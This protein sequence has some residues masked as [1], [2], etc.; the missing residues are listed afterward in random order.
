MSNVIFSYRASDRLRNAEAIATGTRGAENRELVVALADLSKPQRQVLIEAVTLTGHV[1]EVARSDQY[2]VASWKAEDLAVN[3]RSIAVRDERALSGGL[4]ARPQAVYHDEPLTSETAVN[5]TAERVNAL[6]GALSFHNHVV[7]RRTADYEECVQ[8]LE[9]DEEL[10]YKRASE[11]GIANWAPDNLR[12]ISAMV[13]SA[14]EA[15][16]RAL[17]EADRARR[18]ADKARR[19]ADKASWIEA[20]GSDHLKEAFS[21]GYDSQRQYVIERAAADAPGWVVDFNGSAVWNDRSF[22]SVEALRVEDEA[23]AL[24]DRLGDTGAATGVVWLTAPPSASHDDDEMFFEQCEAVVVRRYLGR[25][26]LVRMV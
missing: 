18:E 25:Y 17:A 4:F 2:A 10:A 9:S 19:E 6:A 7:A 1:R 12:T 23:D 26:D 8:L 5:A 3:L 14:N 24:A 15:R 22:P 13:A 11:A 21:R 16:R 20:H